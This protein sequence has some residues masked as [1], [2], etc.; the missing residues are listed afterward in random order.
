VS[1]A[2]RLPLRL[3]VASTVLALLAA[4]ATYV[5][6]DGGGDDGPSAADGT[7]QLTP[8]EDVAVD[9]DAAVFT[10]FDDEAVPLTSLRGTPVLVNFFASTCT[11]CIKEMPALEAVHQDL[12]DQV[13]FLGLATQDRP[14]EALALV[15]RTGVTYRT[16]QDPDG[17]VI[18]ALGGLALPT[19]V[20][21]DASGE[22]VATHTGELSEGELRSLIAGSF[23]IES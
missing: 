4:V 2:P 18:T 17:S 11:P 8:Q 7:I 10:T 13:T 9:P 23:G 15:E 20:L 16:A 22:I 14:E 3:I 6:L 5:V 19:T 12:G 1:D 21:L